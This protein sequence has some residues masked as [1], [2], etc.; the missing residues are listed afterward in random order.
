MLGTKQKGIITEL[1]CLSIFSKY[2]FDVSIPYGDNARYDFIADINNHLLRIQVKTCHCF[3]N[4]EGEIAGIEFATKST[5]VNCTGV[6]KKTYSLEEIDYFATVWDNICYIVP[7]EQCSSKKRLW[8]KSP[9]NPVKTCC[10]AE[11]FILEKQLADYI[12]DNEDIK[13][14]L[15][16]EQLEK[17]NPIK[18]EYSNICINCGKPVTKGVTG[19][20]QKC[21]NKKKAE[22]IPTKEELKEKIYNN[23]F[24][25]V[26]RHYGVT[27]NA[28]RRWCKK[29]N[30]P[31]Q[32]AI[33]KKFSQEEWSL[34]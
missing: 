16:S 34:L 17:N 30:L 31:Y 2:G 6:N 7:V 32:K 22:H 14:Y 33:I 9:K 20:C 18:S 23:S 21:Y 4:Q 28:V 15:K 13:K 12:D 29:Y 19:L 10:M 26:G 27:D 24:V 11:D 1:Q 5:I 25:Q 8:F 3:A